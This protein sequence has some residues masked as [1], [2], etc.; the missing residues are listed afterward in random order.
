MTRISQQ[1]RI[2]LGLGILLVSATAFA[3]DGSMDVSDAG[4]AR[5]ESTHALNQFQAETRPMQSSQAMNDGG[6]FPKVQTKEDEALAKRFSWWPTDAKPAPVKDPNRSGYWWWPEVPGEARPWGNQGF[7]YVRKIIFDYKSS[8]GNMK[9]SLVIKRVIKNVKVFF[10]YDKSNLRD[11]AMDVLDR[12]LYTMEHNP[13]ADLLITGNAD[14][15]GSEQYNQKLGEKRALA[16]RDYLI[17]KGLPEDRIRILSRGKLDAMA[18]TH[19]IVGMQK[20]RN[21]QFMIAEVEEVMIP[22]EKAHLFQDKIIEEK[23]ELE[24]EIKVDTKD[25]VIQAGDSLWKIA[26][27]EYGNGMQWKRIY[28]FNKDVISNPDRPK[29]GTKIKI[30]IE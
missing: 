4:D 30:P 5:V 8:E 7:V 26:E 13:K 1:F 20:D 27:R 11:D 16:V 19:D 3:D 21:A 12:S 25:Y 24:G 14:I 2:F 10:D 6:N 17:E 9:P 18:P 23:E 15:R 28:E 29:K 22:A